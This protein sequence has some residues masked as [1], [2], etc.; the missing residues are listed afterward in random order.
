MDDN[1]LCACSSLATH[2][3]RCQVS[4]VFLCSLC[5]KDHF[6]KYPAET[7]VVEKLCTWNA[8]LMSA[9]QS[10]PKTR[11]KLRVMRGQAQVYLQ[12]YT[13]RVLKEFDRMDREL[14]EVRDELR[15]RLPS[16]R[17]EQVA[18]CC[19]HLDEVLTPFFDQE[20]SRLWSKQ[21]HPSPLSEVLRSVKTEDCRR[22]ISSEEALRTKPQFD[23]SSEVTLIDDDPNEA[24]DYTKFERD[25]E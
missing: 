24:E 22:C 20:F 19:H 18:C 16:T 15:G 25:F 4:P 6:T 1:T 12:A 23:I 2:R 10:L 11:E 17:A 5:V 9:D 3:C 8:V 14:S 7:H 13:Q 21:S